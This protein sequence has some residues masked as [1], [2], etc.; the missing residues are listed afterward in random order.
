MSRSST[1]AVDTRVKNKPYD[2]APKKTNTESKATKHIHDPE[3]RQ[4]TGTRTRNI[5]DWMKPTLTSISHSHSHSDSDSHSH[6]HSD[7]HSHANSQSHTHSHSHYHSH[8]HSHSPSH[9]SSHS[10]PNSH[11]ASHPDSHSH[12]HCC[13]HTPSHSG[14]HSNSQTDTDTHSHPKLHKG[15]R[16]T[17]EK[18]L[19]KTSWPNQHYTCARNDDTAILMLSYAPGK[20]ASCGPNTRKSHHTKFRNAPNSLYNFCARKFSMTPALTVERTQNDHS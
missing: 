16:K 12:S 15:P 3:Y 14:S 4:N 13:S 6:S 2:I 18:N 7:S 19:K 10:H 9:S 5:H 8:S 17:I 11:S 20:Q 1:D